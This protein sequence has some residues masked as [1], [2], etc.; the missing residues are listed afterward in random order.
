LIDLFLAIP[1][2]VLFAVRPE[3]GWHST[4]VHPGGCNRMQR[5]VAL[6]NLYWAPMCRSFQF[7]LKSRISFFFF[8]SSRPGA[9]ALNIF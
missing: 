9:F 5:H 8:A 7:F 2:G 6:I 1:L 3:S 4:A